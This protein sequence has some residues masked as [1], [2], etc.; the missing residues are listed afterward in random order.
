MPAQFT[1]TSMR[2]RRCSTSATAR[3]TLSSDV[4]SS[5]TLAAYSPAG[6]ALMSATAARAPSSA[7]S[8]A[9]APPM[10]PAAPV[11]SAHFPASPRST[12]TCYAPRAMRPGVV[13][14]LPGD[15]AKITPE[16]AQAVRALGF[17]GASITLSQPAD[18]PT[19][20]LDHARSVL[21]DQGLRVAQSNARYP[22]LVHPDEAMRQEGIRLAQAAVRAA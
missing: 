22:A 14:L 6:G 19:A 20:A 7:S 1:R 8:C 15:P 11:I 3:C 2:P 4:T 16:H 9:V 10:P 17:T 18:V 5:A 13:G 12:G 21:A